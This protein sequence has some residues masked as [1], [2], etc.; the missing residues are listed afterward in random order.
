MSSEQQIPTAEVRLQGYRGRADYGLAVIF[1]ATEVRRD[2]DLV[3]RFLALVRGRA[4]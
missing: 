3:E 4:A 1:S 2:L